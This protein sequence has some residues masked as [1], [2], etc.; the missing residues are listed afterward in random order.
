MASDKQI[1]LLEP[2]TGMCNKLAIT[3]FANDVSAKE[4]STNLLSQ[5]TLLSEQDY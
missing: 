2:I 1:F 3:W 5:I 4:K